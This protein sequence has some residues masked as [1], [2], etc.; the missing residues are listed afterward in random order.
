MPRWVRANQLERADLDEDGVRWRCR[1]SVRQ[2]CSRS[3]RFRCTPI[4]P[5][6]PDG[7]IPVSQQP[8]DVSV[9]FQRLQSLLLTASGVESFLQRLTELAPN[10]VEIPVS[11]GVT[12]RRDGQPLTV[13]SSDEQ[14]RGLDESQ[15]EAAAGPCLH[16]LETGEVMSVP[17]VDLEQRWPG[18]LEEAREKGLRSSLSLPLVVDGSTVAAMNLYSFA[19]P[20][21]F[22][23]QV[24]RRC[25]VFASLA[26]GALQL[27]IGR[28]ADRQLV[29]QLEEALASRTVIDQASGILMGQQYCSAEEAFSLLRMR[30]QSSQRRLREVAGDLIVRVTGEPPQPGRRFDR[31]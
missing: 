21:V 31:S 3:C 19:G 20:G 12:A 22:D 25:R 28:A 26:A 7:S 8:G 29:D 18:Y 23:E 27:A 13:A 11:C 24:Q 15:Y 30:S 17:D 6:G 9:V 4:G 1:W 16:T 5:V 2:D 10:A 14:A